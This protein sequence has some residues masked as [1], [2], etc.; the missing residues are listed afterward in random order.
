MRSSSYVILVFKRIRKERINDN[1]PGA[2]ILDFIN[3]Y[4]HVV[5]YFTYII[6]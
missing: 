1:G 5:Y 6:E 3:W 2:L 4:K